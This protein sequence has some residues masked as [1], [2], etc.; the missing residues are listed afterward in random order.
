MTIL[1]EFGSKVHHHHREKE[2][3]KVDP[4]ISDLIKRFNEMAK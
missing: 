3:P 1:H 4:R 2:E